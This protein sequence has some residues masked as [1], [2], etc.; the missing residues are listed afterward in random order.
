MQIIMEIHAGE[1][2]D[3][4]CLLVEDMFKAY[5]KFFERKG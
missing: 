3:H 2:G 1:G 5:K 4:A